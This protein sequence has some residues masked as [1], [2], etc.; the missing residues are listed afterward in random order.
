MATPIFWRTKQQRYSLR[1]AVCPEC[2]QAVFPPRRVCPHCAHEQA[3]AENDLYTIDARAYAF[4]MPQP[5]R[6]SVAGDD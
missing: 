6:V 4:V 1:G 5:A 2:A 3:Q